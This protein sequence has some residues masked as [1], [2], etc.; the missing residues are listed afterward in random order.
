MN[1][2]KKLFGKQTDSESHQVKRGPS[3]REVAEAPALFA[4]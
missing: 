2:L 4:D 1:L 3:A